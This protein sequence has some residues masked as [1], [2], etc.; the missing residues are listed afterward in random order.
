MSPDFPH[1][2]AL[3]PMVEEQLRFGNSGRHNPDR[4]SGTARERQTWNPVTKQN[5]LVVDSGL[6]AFSAPQNDEN[7]QTTAAGSSA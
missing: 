2:F 3:C 5:L 4:H 7:R 1:G 6:R